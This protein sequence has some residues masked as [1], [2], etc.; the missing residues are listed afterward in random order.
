[1]LHHRRAVPFALAQFGFGALAL[2]NLLRQFNR[3]LRDQTFKLDALGSLGLLLPY[4]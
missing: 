2:G 1:V 3:A 4:I